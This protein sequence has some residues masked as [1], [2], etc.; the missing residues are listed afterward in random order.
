MGV[1]YVLVIN[2]RRRCAGGYSSLSVCL[3]VCKSCNLVLSLPNPHTLLLSTF[4]YSAI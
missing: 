1:T 3:Y 2:P 4:V